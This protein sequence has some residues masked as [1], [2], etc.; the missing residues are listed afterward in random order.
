MEQ[1]SS[2]VMMLVARVLN[3][4]GQFPDSLLLLMARVGAGA[5]FFKSGLTKI[6]LETMSIAPSTF[7]LF[8][9]EYK[10]PLLPPELAAY[11]GT[12]NELLLPVLLVAGLFA[13][14]G[15]AGLLG[16]T[17]TIQLFVYP[18]NW[19]EHLIW[20]TLLAM[21]LTRGPGAISLDRLFADRFFERR[22]R[23]AM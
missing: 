22:P 11:L 5:V 3:L 18:E 14:I 2:G 16:M 17:A 7:D 1:R 19:A 10:V 21:V 4:L 8:R 13:R 9:D 20:A 12:F 23:Y 6:D 15:A